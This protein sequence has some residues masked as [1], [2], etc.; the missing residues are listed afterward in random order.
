MKSKIL[1]ALILI[2]TFL[3]GCGS[4]SQ[5]DPQASELDTQLMAAVQSYLELKDALVIADAK[6]ASE[7]AKRFETALGAI[8]ENLFPPGLLAGWQLHKESMFGAIGSLIKTDDLMTQRSEFFY[9]SDA[10]IKVLK[11]H[12]PLEK[13][14]YIQHCPMAFDNTGG[15]WISDAEKIMNPYFGDLMLHCGV[16]QEKI[17]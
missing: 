8:D 12:G 3:V 7:K 6:A 2:S 11:N 16:V 5:P 17:K 1:I 14:L 9:V 4:N 10:L 13:P 15:D